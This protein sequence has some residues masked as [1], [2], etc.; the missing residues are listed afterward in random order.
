MD[1]SGI[2]CLCPMGKFNVV[3]VHTRFLRDYGDQRFPFDERMS[4]MSNAQTV[5]ST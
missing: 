3:C 2:A 5:P 1:D 4:R